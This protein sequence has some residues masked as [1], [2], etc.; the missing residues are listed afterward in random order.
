MIQ[1]LLV[2][3]LT[4]PYVIDGGAWRL[5]TGM[6]ISANFHEARR[7]KSQYRLDQNTYGDR[8][9]VYPGTSL[10]RR[11][12]DSSPIM[13]VVIWAGLVALANRRI[14]MCFTMDYPKVWI[15]S[16]AWLK[17]SDTTAESYKPSSGFSRAGFYLVKDSGRETQ[18]SQTNCD[19]QTQ[20]R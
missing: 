2:K 8:R 16:N 17:E 11:T 20:K 5:V 14:R 15:L 9:A 18:R 3:A 10:P 13:P 12:A 4:P 19:E 1:W 7:L 6:D